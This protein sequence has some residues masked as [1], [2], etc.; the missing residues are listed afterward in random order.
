MSLKVRILLLT[1]SILF[2]TTLMLSIISS[3]QLK[4]LH[5]ESEKLFISSLMRTIQDAIVRDTLDGNKLKV[6]RFLKK[7][8]ED[9]KY[10]DFI[11]VIDNEGYMFAHSFKDGFPSYLIKKSRESVHDHIHFNTQ[12][13]IKDLRINEYNSLLLPGLISSVSIGV[14]QTAF[15]NKFSDDLIFYILVAGIISIFALLVLLFFTKRA[16]QPL[17]LLSKTLSSYKKDKNLPLHL[18]KTSSSEILQ[19]ITV[20]KALFHERDSAYETLERQANKLRITL[21]SI[22]DAVIVTDNETKIIN[23]NSVAENLTQWKLKEAKSRPLAEIFPIIDASTGQ[24]I[25][26][27]AKVVLRDK[28]TLYLTNHTTLIGKN[29]SEFQI[30]D[31]AAPIINQNN[32]IE[33]VVIVF[34]DVTEQYR[35]RERSKGVLAQFDRLLKN[36]QTQIWL[37]ETD[38]SIIFS[39]NKISRVS[40]N[41]LGNKVWQASPFDSSNSLSASI[42]SLFKSVIASQEASTI[43]LEIQLNEKQQWITFNAMPVFNDAGSIIQVIAEGHDITSSKKATQKIDYQAHHDMLTALP[44]RHSAIERLSELID[45]SK[46]NY[47][48][49]FAVLFLDLDNFKNYNDTL[50]HDYGDKILIKTAKLLKSLI[51]NN[52]F[53]AR[54]GG[55]E[56]IILVNDLKNSLD[57]GHLAQKIVNAF[58]QHVELDFREI[59]LTVSIGISIY[60]VNGPTLQELL[61]NSDTAM[62]HSKKIGR[63]TFSYFTK[64]MNHE[65]MRQ[66]QIEEKMHLALKNNLFEVYFQPK[67]NMS[68]GLIAGAEALLRWKDKDLGSISPDLF[69]PIAEKSDLIIKIGQLVLGKAL[70]ALSLWVSF[71]PVDFRISINLSPVEFQNNKLLTTIKSELAKR[72]LSAKFLEYE[73]TETA[74]SHEHEQAQDLL[75]SLQALGITIA[76][77]DFGTGYS[78]LSYLRTYS[79]DTIKIDKSFVSNMTHD[80]KDRKLVNASISMAK[81]L[82]LQIVAEGVETQEQFDLLKNMECD[83]A[84]GYHFAKALPADEIATMIKKN[85]KMIQLK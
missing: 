54:L 6:S 3:Y 52:D 44:N 78:S 1:A 63:N 5:L 39:N 29:G 77:D 58:N 67:I 36:I 4:T 17:S 13:K 48:R 47:N 79:F 81:S 34:H 41:T 45:A 61:K 33:G 28:K 32:K 49:P 42:E 59:K 71:L 83:Y 60:P 74:L 25:E 85:Q 70:D 35:L 66:L 40:D 10:I 72:E 26:D 15:L 9:D 46:R 7:I 30:A 11:Y 37:M 69:I 43:E 84:Q 38:G 27:P 22:G 51:R 53:L 2:I 80:I 31:S 73:I 14:N 56:F 68:S 65:I 75:D 64:E 19:L 23:M 20:L 12:Y 50:G 55:D 82:D 57:V 21:E 62:Y 8:T 24:S 18:I 76:M 16:M